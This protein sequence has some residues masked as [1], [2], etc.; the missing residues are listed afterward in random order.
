[1]GWDIQKKFVPWDGMIFKNFR[2]IPSHG[3]WFSKKTYHGTGWDG[4]GS[5]HPTR[6]PAVNGSVQASGL[7]DWYFW[8]RSRSRTWRKYLITHDHDHDDKKSSI[9]RTITITTEKKVPNHARSR[10]IVIVKSTI[11]QDTKC[12]SSWKYVFSFSFFLWVDDELLAIFWFKSEYDVLNK[13]LRFCT[14]M[15]KL[16]KK[17]F[18]LNHD[19]D[20]EENV[21]SCTITITT[22]KKVPNH[23]RSRSRRQ[24]KLLITHDHAW[25][26]PWSW[27]WSWNRRS[28][29]TLTAG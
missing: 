11:T 25:S 13:H 24:K 22:K 21:W 5:S 9:S 27:S 15:R 28:R 17:N 29:R 7:R 12:H 2:P 4:M 18:C 26:W 23:A 20:H 8:S 19:H 3:T 1:M 16:F 14:Y 6:S 10:V